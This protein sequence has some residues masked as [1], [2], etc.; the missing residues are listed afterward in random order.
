[1]QLGWVILLQMVLVGITNYIQLRVGLAQIGA[2]APITGLVHHCF[3]ERPFH[4]LA[5]LSVFGLVMWEAELKRTHTEALQAV[6]GVPARYF[7]CIL[8]VKANDKYRLRK[9]GVQIDSAF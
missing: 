2:R 4:W 3:S 1:M 6:L 7:N 9:K 5:W 8:L